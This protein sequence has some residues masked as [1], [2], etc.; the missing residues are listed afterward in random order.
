MDIE[1]INYEFGDDLD[2]F[3]ELIQDFKEEAPSMF[4][5]IE[6]A[7]AS[8]DANEVMIVAHTFKGVVSNF[9]SEKIKDCAFKMETM[10]RDGDISEIPKYLEE[11]KSLYSQLLIDLEGF[12]NQKKAS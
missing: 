12:L 7:H 10:G 1:K 6:K 4:E 11:L 3:E 9:Y 2:I 8:G 5:S